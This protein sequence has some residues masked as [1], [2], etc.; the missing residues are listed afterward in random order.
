MEVTQL[1]LNQY[2]DPTFLYISAKTPTAI[3]TSPVNTKYALETYIL[4]KMGIYTKYVIDLYGRCIHLCATYEV[5]AINHVT[6]CTVHIF[7]IYHRKNM[8]TTLHI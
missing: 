5:I 1:T 4:T 6:T 3:H 2:P 7:D 8:A